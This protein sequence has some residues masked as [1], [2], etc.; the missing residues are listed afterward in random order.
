MKSEIF[1]EA[2]ACDDYG[3]GPTYASV[4][5]DDSFVEEIKA[6]DALINEHDL[7][8]VRKFM[9]PEHWGPKGVADELMLQCG[10]LV[11]VRGGFFRFVD[12]PRHADYS[13][14]TRAV[15][16]NLVLKGIEAGECVFGDDVENLKEYLENETEEA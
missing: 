6:L 7:T 13:V 2:Y 14:K 4:V 15:G 5:I 11:V 16:I 3:D 12:R 8:E 9:T 10:E 1:I